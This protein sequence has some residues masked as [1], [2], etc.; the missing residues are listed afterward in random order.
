M[1]FGRRSQRETGPAMLLVGL[2]NPGPDYARHRHNVG[3]MAVD[4]VAT[5]YGFRPFRSK[6]R[7]QLADGTIDGAKVLALKPAT[8]MNESGRSVA[9]AARF[10]KLS[11][12]RITVVYDELDLP[13][14]KCRVKRGGGSG[15]HNGIRSIDRH[16]G[17]DY[18]RVRLGIGHPGDK[19]LVHG[20]VLH[21]FAKAD[22]TWLEPLLSA[23]A[24]S[25]PLLVAGHPDR[26][27]NS[28]AHGLAG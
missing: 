27:Q 7:G 22:Q 8:Y 21:D 2:G 18:W 1:L 23:V 3:Y 11:P 28:V 26:F 12:E 20:Y 16:I 17:P 4:T 9:E 13:P 25:L 15:G 24:K 14:G 6:F 19:A 10:Y 5:E